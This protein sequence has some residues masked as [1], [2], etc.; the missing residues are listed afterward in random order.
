MMDA[1]LKSIPTAEQ[2]PGIIPVEIPRRTFLQGIVS[3]GAVL[4]A[5]RGRDPDMIHL[6]RQ[7]GKAFGGK[8]SCIQSIRMARRGM[9]RGTQ[10]PNE[11]SPMTAIWRWEI[12]IKFIDETAMADRRA[13]FVEFFGEQPK[14]G[15][16]S[17]PWGEWYWSNDLTLSAAIE[18][19]RE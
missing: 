3:M 14:F 4:L 13:W 5:Q 10:R 8:D 1:E 2:L 18:A 9:F 6:P 7:I 16:V 11:S 19:P 12:E 15:E 17:I